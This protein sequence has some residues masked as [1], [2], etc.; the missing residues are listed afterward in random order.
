MKIVDNLGLRKA[1]I[2]SRFYNYNANEYSVTDDRIKFMAGGFMISIELSNTEEGFLIS[3]HE[4]SGRD[5]IAF[6]EKDS[7]KILDR[8]EDRILYG[9]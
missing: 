7:N 8:I 5:G 3:L 2:I 6:V 9:L 4:C 1:D